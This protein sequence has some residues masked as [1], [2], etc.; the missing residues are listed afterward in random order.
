MFQELA[1]E[2]PAPDTSLARMQALDAFNVLDAALLAL[3][4]AITEA[5]RDL[6]AYAVRLPFPRIEPGATR[7]PRETTILPVALMGPE[8]R[9]YLAGLLRATRFAPEQ[10]PQRVLRCPGLFAMSRA[11]E[12]LAAEVNV[13]KSAFESAYQAISVTPT[14]RR[15]QIASVV[16]GICLLQAY[17]ELTLLAEPPVKVGFLWASHT[18]KVRRITVAALREDLRKAQAR[19][20]EGVDPVQWEMDLGHDLAVLASLPDTEYVAVRQPLAPHPRANIYLP[21]QA[22]PAVRPAALPIGYPDDGSDALPPIRPLGVLDRRFRRA[23]R[24]DVKVEG[25]PLLAHRHVFRYKT[26]HRKQAPVEPD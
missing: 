12:A 1:P 16:P 4:Q 22:A 2:A 19:P 23:V 15:E 26:A 9:T 8:A 13:A 17:R 3:A 11:T 14:V 21:G 20:P 6:P 24:S 25:T 7:A 5:D 18:P 10:H